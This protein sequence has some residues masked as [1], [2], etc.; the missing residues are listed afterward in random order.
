MPIGDRAWSQRQRDSQTRDRA[1]GI[2]RRLAS[3][4]NPTTWWSS[5]PRAVCAGECRRTNLEAADGN[6]EQADHGEPDQECTRQRDQDKTGEA[7]D[8]QRARTDAE[9]LGRARV[10]AGSPRQSHCSMSGR[11]LSLAGI[12]PGAGWS[13]HHGGR[14]ACNPARLTLPRCSQRT[15]TTD[16]LTRSTIVDFAS[17]ATRCRIDRADGEVVTSAR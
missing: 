4:T 9:R 5:A 8:Q 3:P 6:R 10:A 14:L 11:R 17:T 16:R 15:T 13:L 2:M 12:A 7:G 1:D